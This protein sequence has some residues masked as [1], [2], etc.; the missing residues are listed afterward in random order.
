MGKTSDE[1]LARIEHKQ[2]M[3]LDIMMKVINKTYVTEMKDGSHECPVCRVGVKYVIDMQDKSVSRRCGCK[4]GKF[5]PLDLEPP[6]AAGEK[7]DAEG[8][9]S[10]DS[11]GEG[12]D[13]PRG[14]GNSQGSRRR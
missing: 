11:V 6:M 1:A 13:A 8:S 5:A 10:G 12:D 9:G 3:M 7:R 2:D 14:R 4:T